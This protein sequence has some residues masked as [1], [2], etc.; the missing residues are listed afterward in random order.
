[1]LSTRLSRVVAVA[2]ATLVVACGDPTRPK[3]TT[4]NLLLSYSVHTFTGAAPAEASG[5]SIA[6]WR[7]VA[8]SA[9]PMP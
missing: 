2:I 9:R 4:P 7:I 8:R 1:M 3:A 5:S 6:A